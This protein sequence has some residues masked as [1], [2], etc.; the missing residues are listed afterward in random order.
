MIFK[1]TKKEKD[2]YKIILSNFLSA[3]EINVLQLVSKVVGKLVKN[4][5]PTIDWHLDGQL[6]RKMLRF[7]QRWNFHLRILHNLWTLLA[8]NSFSIFSRLNCSEVHRGTQW[9]IPF[10]LSGN[11]KRVCFIF[12]SRSFRK[13]KTFQENW[14]HLQ[15]QWD[16]FI[17]AVT[18]V[19][20][21]VIT[22]TI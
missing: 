10:C 21:V 5:V 12:G 2:S 13:T 15:V 8:L 4:H 17:V 3:K 19:I 16:G 18:V 22:R 6:I 7:G 1:N 20:F 11:T 14:R 9:K